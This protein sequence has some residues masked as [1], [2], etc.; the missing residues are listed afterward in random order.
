[1]PK[2]MFAE[3]TISLHRR[4]RRWQP[5]PAH[6]LGRAEHLEP[7]LDKLLIGIAG[8]PVGRGDRPVMPAGAAL[9]IARPG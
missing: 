4:V 9:L 8:N 6:L 7:A 2:A 1:M 3:D 5:L